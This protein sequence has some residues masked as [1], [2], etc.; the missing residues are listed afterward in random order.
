M[1]ALHKGLE[2]GHRAARHVGGE[3]VLGEDIAAEPAARDR[4]RS[5]L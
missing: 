1:D 4:S 2:A 5:N 3:V